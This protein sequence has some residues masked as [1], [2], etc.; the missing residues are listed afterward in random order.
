MCSLI[1]SPIRISLGMPTVAIAF[2]EASFLQV[3]RVRGNANIW[4]A[5][6]TSCAN[7]CH[8]NCIEARV[9]DLANDAQHSSSHA[10]R[11]TSAE[12]QTRNFTCHKEKAPAGE[13][14][15]ILDPASVSGL[16][17]IPVSAVSLCWQLRTERE[18]QVLTNDYSSDLRINGH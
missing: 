3:A 16:Y 13:L 6:E 15:Q 17:G 5:Y 9:L 11:R 12:S 8:L 18:K 4:N 7:R 14:E 2:Q 10:A 1:T